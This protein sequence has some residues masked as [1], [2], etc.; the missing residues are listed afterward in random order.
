[1]RVN[2]VNSDRSHT[3]YRLSMNTGHPRF[4]QRLQTIGVLL[5]IAGLTTHVLQYPSLLFAGVLLTILLLVRL[6][7]EVSI[8]GDETDPV[9][10]RKLKQLSILTQVSLLVAGF[11]FFVYLRTR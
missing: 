3:P 11:G 7:I 9:M 2:K 5:F 6:L 1:M 8:R 4:L 10:E